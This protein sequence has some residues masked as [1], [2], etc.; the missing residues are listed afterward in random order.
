MVLGLYYITKGKKSAPP[1]KVKGE[2]LVFYSPQEVAIAYNEGKVDL[3][4]IV[5][6][7]VNDRVDGELVNHLLKRLS[8]E[9]SSI[10]MFRLKSA[11]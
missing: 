5:K 4:A 6:V 8:E 1:E 10:R 3:H 9:F 2:G 7:K 11:I